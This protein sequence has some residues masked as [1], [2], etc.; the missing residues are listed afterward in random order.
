MTTTLIRIT[1]KN[2]EWRDY[3]AIRRSVLWE[4]RGDFS[5]NDHHPDDTNAANHALLLI[6]NGRAAGTT[7]LD[8]FG[9]GSGAVRLVAI[10]T[11]LQKRGLGRELAGH[12][13]DYARELGLHTLYVNA[14]P[15]AV[16]YY[17]KMGW[18]FFTWDASELTGIAADCM[19]MRK[20]LVF[21]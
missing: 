3:H 5:Y 20:P 11:D 17:E 7:R 4:A 2:G 12:T 8:D 1:D 16:G 10:A 18:S 6:R 15:E 14:A 19:Q 13:D 9:D 21:E